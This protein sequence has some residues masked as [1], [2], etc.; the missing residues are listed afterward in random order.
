VRTP[1]QILLESTTI[2]VVGASRH[3]AKAA[4]AVPLQLKLHG[5]SVIPVNPFAAEIWG[6]PCWPDLASVSVPIDLV[7]VFRPA[8]DTPEVARQA[9][10]VGARAVWLQQGIVSPAARS[11][12]VAAGLDY[13]EDLC[14]AVVRA[15]H[16]LSRLANPAGEVVQSGE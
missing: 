9:A 12:T 14:I 3:E 4:Y 11:I 10:A 13:V 1:A 7:N 16:R 8:P 2:A 5:W 15:V 6:V